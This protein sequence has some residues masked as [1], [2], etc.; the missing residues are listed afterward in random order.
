[1]DERSLL[2]SKTNPSNCTLNHLILPIDSLGYCNYPTSLICEVLSSHWDTLISIQT[3][4]SIFHFKSTHTPIPAFPGLCTYSSNYYSIFSFP[5]LSIPMFS[6][7]VL[8]ILSLSHPN[9]MF[10]ST[11]L[12]KP[13]LMVSNSFHFNK[14]NGQF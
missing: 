14:P 7:S 6:G 5:E 10:I 11:T 1:M 13:L 9:Q 3:C 2:M 8:P 4:C 12:L